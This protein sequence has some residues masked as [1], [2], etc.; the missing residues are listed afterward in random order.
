M[1]GAVMREHGHVRPA[2]D[3]GEHAIAARRVPDGPDARRVDAGA[4]LGVAEEP[5]QHR[6][7]LAWAAA[8]VP[9][10]AAVSAVTPTVASV[11]RRGHDITALGQTNRRVAV[12]QAAAPGPVR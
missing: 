9:R 2:A 7:Q 8:P 6:A 11:L 1:T 5:I 12:I 3:Q 4:E 10:R